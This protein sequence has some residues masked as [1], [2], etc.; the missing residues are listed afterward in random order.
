MLPRLSCRFQSALFDI[1]NNKL[2]ATKTR[3]I[4]DKPINTTNKIGKLYIDLIAV[5]QNLLFK[6]L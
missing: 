6:V 1:F 3:V 4:S 2:P 5:A